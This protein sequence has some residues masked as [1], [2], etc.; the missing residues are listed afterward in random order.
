M[1]LQPLKRILLVLALSLGCT[2][3]AALLLPSM[4][5]AQT[6]ASTTDFPGAKDHPAI[7]RFAGS[8]IVAYDSKKF[9]ELEIPIS[10]YRGYNT[11]TKKG[12]FVSAPI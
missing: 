2:G 3:F 6:T 8:V 11:D 5:H 4:S 1:L 9:D 10:T 12:E 7:K